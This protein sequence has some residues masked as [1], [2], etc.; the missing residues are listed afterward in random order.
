MFDNL[1]SFFS[2]LSG[3]IGRRHAESE[4]DDEIAQHLDL[5]AEENIRRGMPPEEAR[6]AARRSFG[7]VAQ[8]KETQRELRGLPQVDILWG[9][10]RYAVRTLR[11]NPGFTLVAV[12]TLALGIGVNTT[13]FSAF[14]AVALK[15]LPVSDPGSVVRL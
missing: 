11:Q 8:A 3:L 13:L 15:P 6:M 14:N 9:D 12:L 5:L 7:G 2:R 10:L 4:F 1:F